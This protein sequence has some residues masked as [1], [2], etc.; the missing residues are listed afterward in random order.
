MTVV[1]SKVEGTGGIE[2]DSFSGDV[3]NESLFEEVERN[4]QQ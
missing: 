2:K 4:G 1:F 3:E